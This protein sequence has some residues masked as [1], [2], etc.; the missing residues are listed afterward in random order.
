MDW[1]NFKS[2]S[3]AGD[4][5]I[6][7]AKLMANQRDVLRGLFTEFIKA[8]GFVAWHIHDG[9]VRNMD[10][11]TGKDVLHNENIQIVWFDDHSSHSS[12]KCPDLGDKM[13]VVDYYYDSHESEPFDIY[14]YAVIE[15]PRANDVKLKRIEVK[16]AVFNKEENNYQFLN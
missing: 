2:N 8:N 4:N 9:W 11:K 16:Q 15:K 6:L 13:V 1:K 10:D 14:C 7:R 3:I 5:L 12:G